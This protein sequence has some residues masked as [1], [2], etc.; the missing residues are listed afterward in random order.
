MKRMERMLRSSGT[1]RC[2]GKVM[3]WRADPSLSHTKDSEISDGCTLIA[4]TFPSSPPLGLVPLW[5]P[6]SPE[7]SCSSD[8]HLRDLGALQPPN[9]DPRCSDHHLTPPDL[10]RREY[11]LGEVFLI[12]CYV[13]VF[14]PSRIFFD[15]GSARVTRCR[16]YGAHPDKTEMCI[17]HLTPSAEYLLSLDTNVYTSLSNLLT[18]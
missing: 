7:S 12:P 14:T 11:Y 2:C 18:Q 3:P 17:P 8:K 13:K 15:P 16:V 4:D 10:H 5:C 6:A 1:C 9:S